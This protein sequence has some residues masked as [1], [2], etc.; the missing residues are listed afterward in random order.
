MTVPAAGQPV[1]FAEHIKP[2]FRP[3]DRDSMAFAFDLWDLESVRSHA[4]AILSR[5]RQGSMPCD[6]RWPSER[7][8]LVARWIANGKLD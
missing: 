7:V 2:L 4:D 5:L 3:T 6:G 1:G 8:E